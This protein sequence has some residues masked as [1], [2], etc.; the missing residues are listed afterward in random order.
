ME[1]CHGS[2]QRASRSGHHGGATQPVLV[3]IAQC[4]AFSRRDQLPAQII[5]SGH[6]TCGHVFP[7]VLIDEEDGLAAFDFLYPIIFLRRIT[8]QVKIPPIT[9][10]AI[11]EVIVDQSGR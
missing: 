2:V 3:E 6:N 7:V 9:R 8:S 11:P 1:K 4:G 5:G 10:P